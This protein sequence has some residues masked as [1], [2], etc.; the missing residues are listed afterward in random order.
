MLIEEHDVVGERQTRQLQIMSQLDLKR[1][2]VGDRMIDYIYICKG[3]SS[4]AIAPQV[5]ELFR[6]RTIAQTSPNIV[7][8]QAF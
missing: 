7:G 1:S 6:Y 3:R 4:G 2:M 5:R 8:F